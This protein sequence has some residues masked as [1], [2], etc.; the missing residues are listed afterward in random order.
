MFHLRQDMN[1]LLDVFAS[2]ASPRSLQSLLLN[3]LGRIF[4]TRMPFQNAV[5]R[6]ELTA[7]KWTKNQSVPLDACPRNLLL[8]IINK[9]KKSH[10]QKFKTFFLKNW[11]LK[12]DTIEWFSNIENRY[13]KM[14]SMIC[15]H[16]IIASHE[17]QRIV[18]WIKSID[19]SV[20]LQIEIIV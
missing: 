10:D 1:L 15:K 11:T 20:D 2:N 6:G 12:H 7:E 3:E 8:K 14:K 13:H 5:N 4:M 19:F 9:R 18:L 16:V 17:L